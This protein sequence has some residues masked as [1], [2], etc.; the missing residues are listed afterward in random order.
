[1]FSTV[2]SWTY[3]DFALENSKLSIHAADHTNIIPYR[4]LVESEADKAM[5]FE[6]LRRVEEMSGEDD[7][8]LDDDDDS[9]I[10]AQPAAGGPVVMDGEKSSDENQETKAE[11]ETKPTD[12]DPG[13]ILE[14]AYLRDPNLFDRD[15]NTRRSKAREDLRKATGT[16]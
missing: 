4:S 6:I 15:A 16:I 10:D 13:K 3:R 14:L 12:A 2:T 11:L 8:N 5:K 7:A 9:I 1:M